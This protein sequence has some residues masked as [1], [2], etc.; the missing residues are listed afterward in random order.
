M[1]PLYSGLHIRHGMK[2]HLN[3][4]THV[5][6]DRYWYSGTAYGC[7][8]DLPRSWLENLDKGLPEP[9]IVF[10]INLSPHIAQQRNQHKKE[11]Y[12]IIDTQIK[13][14]EAFE[15]LSDRGVCK[16]WHTLDGSLKKDLLWELIVDKV[17][18]IILGDKPIEW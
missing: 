7:S 5:I 14:H 3:K 8:Q 15:R 4:G 10:Y 18:H 12:D 11:R 9:D 1:F 16:N 17:Q 6:L 13:I 2:E